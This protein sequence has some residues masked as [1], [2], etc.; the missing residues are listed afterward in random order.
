MRSR[1]KLATN[2]FAREIGEHDVEH[3]EIDAARVHRRD[4]GGAVGD[5]RDGEPL[6]L[7]RV[8]EHLADAGFVVDDKD[9]L[10]HVRLARGAPPLRQPF[11]PRP[12]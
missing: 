9:V 5:R 4:R 1:A 6:A 2:L 8:L 12:W 11:M 7:E 3:H 10:A